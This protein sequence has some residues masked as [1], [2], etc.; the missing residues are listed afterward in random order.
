MV[1]SVESMDGDSYQHDSWQIICGSFNTRNTTNYRCNSMENVTLRDA[2]S[3]KENFME[4]WTKHKER[5]CT[6]DAVEGMEGFF[7]EFWMKCIAQN[8]I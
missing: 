5:E 7:V 4:K 1:Q 2:R 8:I 6:E 3:L